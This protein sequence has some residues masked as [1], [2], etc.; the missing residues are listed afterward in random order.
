MKVA[1]FTLGGTIAST[2]AGATK[3]GIDKT[4]SI[5]GR[6]VLL[7]LPSY[8]GVDYLEADDHGSAFG[9]LVRS[10]AGHCSAGGGSGQYFPVTRST[11]NA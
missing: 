2:R 6:G 5:V 4:R 8:H 11:L 3:C 9:D 10:S 7:D 1:L